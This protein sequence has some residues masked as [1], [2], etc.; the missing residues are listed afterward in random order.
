[1]GYRKVDDRWMHRGPGQKSDRDDN[2][3]DDEPDISHSPPP[4]A[5]SVGPLA[6]S[7]LVA[8]IEVPS[9]EPTAHDSLR[10]PPPVIGHTID[11]TLDVVDLITQKI[12]TLFA[13][14]RFDVMRKQYK[15]DNSVKKS[16]TE[17]RHDLIELTLR[18]ELVKKA[19]EEQSEQPE[20]ATLLQETAK[21]QRKMDDYVIEEAAIIGAIH[22][23]IH[24]IEFEIRVLL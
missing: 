10:T 23:E 12:D 22:Q 18:A 16:Y 4:T 8:S 11:R 21:M 14:L 24:W 15:L 9:T 19:Q 5:A 1:M 17:L 7:T 6:P 20:I 3:E 2:E 13:T